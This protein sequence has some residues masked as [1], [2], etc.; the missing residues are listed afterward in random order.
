MFYTFSSIVPAA[1]EDVFSWHTRAGAFARLQPPWMSVDIE[2]ESTSLR[3]GQTVLKLPTLLQ[4]VA[5]HDVA[6]FVEGSQFVDELTRTGL[7]SLPVSG[8]IKWRH[9]HEFERVG[10]Q[11]TLVRDRVETNLA[12]SVL[13]RMFAYRHEQLGTDITAQLRGNTGPTKRLT[14]A[15]TG[16]SGLVGSA[17]SA[18]LTTVGHRVVKLVRHP[19]QHPDERYWE[20]HDPDPQL[21]HGVDALV[22][23]AGSPI[24]GRFTPAHKARIWDS[25]IPATTK[26]AQLLAH[27]EH[28]P[29][30]F[31]CA[32]AIGYY[33]ADH[34]DEALTEDSPAGND[35]LADLVNHWETA[36]QPAAEAGIRVV[37][38]RTGLVQSTAGGMLALLRWLYTAGLGGR[39]GNGQQWMSWIGLDDL[40]Y[41]YHRALTDDRMSGPINATAPRPVRNSEWSTLLAHIVRR[42]NLLPVPRNGLR[43]LLGSQGA[44]EFAA[45]SQRVLPQVLTNLE[46]EFARPT[47]DN[48][49]RHELG[50]HRNMP[51][52]IDPTF[53]AGLSRS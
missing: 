9:T 28:G 52:T 50:R 13:K 17:L 3:N 1:P 26:L 19:T 44:D 47:L 41:I 43:L 5:R 32:S 11:Q 20:P 37:N 38:I 7:Q 27:T 53:T 46:H 18:F 34:A 24:A 36:T 22:H 25:R 51:H 45:A 35:F 8:L 6:G 31:I 2:S 21:L 15:I 42:P 14:V 12:A 30:I 33:G 48:T 4:W 40:V 49:L 39:I 29:K 10:D 16:S 23:L